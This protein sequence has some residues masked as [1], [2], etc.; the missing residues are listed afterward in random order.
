M[1]EYNIIDEDYLAVDIFNNF[2]R[3]IIGKPTLSN[4]EIIILAEALEILERF[5]EIT[6]YTYIEIDISYRNGNDDYEEMQY[7]DFKISEDS[8]DICSGGSTYDKRV[9][10]DWFLG[11]SWIIGEGRPDYQSET[12]LFNL[13]GTVNEL[14]NLGAKVKIYKEG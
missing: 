12:F 5:P 3:R 4:K 7:Y 6:P 11:P 10:S 8:I 13:E 14:L 2:I 1:S 9:G